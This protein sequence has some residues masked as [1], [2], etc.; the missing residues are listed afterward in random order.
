MLPY[1][2]ISIKNKRTVRVKVCVPLGNEQ[3]IFFI[4]EI[5]PAYRMKF[6]D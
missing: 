2:G 3:F 6:F 4:C 5:K 1:A